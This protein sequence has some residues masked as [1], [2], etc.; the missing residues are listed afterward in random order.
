MKIA[1]AG[2][3]LIGGSFFKAFTQTGHEVTGFDIGDPVDVADSDLVIVALHPRAAVEWIAAHAAEFK[4]GALVV[5]TC[6]IKVPVMEGVA[7][8]AHGAR[9]RFCGGHPMAGKEV[10]GFRNSD[11]ALFRGA[12]MILVPGEGIDDDALAVLE[13]AFSEVG[14]KRVVTAEAAHHDKMIAY[15][16]QLCHIVSSAYVRDELAPNHDIF[17]AGSFRDM[18]R[19]GAPDPKLWSELF[20]DNRESL[21]PVLERMIGRMEAMRDAIAAGDREAISA[22]LAEGRIVKAKMD[23]GGAVGKWTNG[24]K[25][26][27]SQEEKRKAKPGDMVR[28]ARAATMGEEWVV[29]K[30]VKS[31]G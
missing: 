13:A 19:V 8:V 5:D 24:R 6:G 17:S 9:W 18:V 29:P 1:V 20:L 4:E 12:T 2:L 10:S 21:L 25:S 3:G 26:G 11:A 14:F 16:S 7:K 31:E 30:E 27:L 28:K 22:Q 23:A 15:T